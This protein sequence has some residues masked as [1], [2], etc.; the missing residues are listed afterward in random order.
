MAKKFIEIASA[1][2]LT[3]IYPYLMDPVPEFTI[4]Q[5]RVF[6]GKLNAFDY[7]TILTD[8]GKNRFGNW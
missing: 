4:R 3:F 5:V 6:R 8:F 2:V 7:L 1:V